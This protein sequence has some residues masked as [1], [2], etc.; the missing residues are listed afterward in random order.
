MPYLYPAVQTLLRVPVILE[1]SDGQQIHHK[2]LGADIQRLPR[3]P[4]VR[5]GHGQ[6]PSAFLSL[7]LQL[8][9]VP[10]FSP[11]LALYYLLQG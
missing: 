8:F 5:Q 7:P 4:T 6:L 11:P 3:E 2:L 10:A 9:S 1:A